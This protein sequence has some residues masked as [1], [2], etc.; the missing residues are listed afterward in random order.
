MF[1]VASIYG[2]HNGADLF[3]KQKNEIER[4]NQETEAE[5][6][7]TLSYYDTGKKGPDE[8]PWVDN[9]EPFWA[10]YNAPT[11]QFKTPSPTIVYAIGQTEQYG[12][13]KRI[14]T[15][16]NPYDAD[17][18]QEIS[19]PERIQSGNL[20]FSFAV[21]FLLPLLLLVL[22]YNIKGLEAERG[23]LP[24]V[25]VQAG[26]K[27][28]WI[29][30]RTAFYA[31]LLLLV[32][33]GL[34]LYGATLTDVFETKNDFWKIF[35]WV[36]ISLFFWLVI[37]FLILYYGNNTVSNTLQM[38]GVWLLL[39]IIIP[40]TIQQWI[41]IEKPTNLMVDLIDVKREKTSEIYEQSKELIDA[42]LFELYP[43][44]K[45]TKTFRDTTIVKNDR[46]YSTDALV[47]IE[48]KNATKGIEADNY[49]KNKLVETTYW[50][51]PVTYFQNKLNKLTSTHYEDYES[52]RNEIQKSVD[53]R[54][55]TMVFDIW[56]NVEVD[57]LRYLEYNA[58]FTN[59]K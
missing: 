40:A 25:I 18:T 28:W 52:Y 53:N 16:S 26:S 23:F 30:S 10:I 45:E 43:D 55:E 32:L 3:E 49:A 21:L 33:F 34:M 44:L 37:Y 50:F 39:A 7:N 48:M 8:Q 58:I 27:N 46:G 5:I 38:I 9:N 17:M 15:W 57:K 31:I 13:Y 54:L 20:D 29:L 56:N 2:L 14:T 42:Q 35:L 4:L 12:F 6:K 24:L 59:D 47:N 19:N 22:L 1:T 36:T 11:Y 51:N 41:A